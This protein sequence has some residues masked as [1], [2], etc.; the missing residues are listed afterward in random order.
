M[1]ISRQIEKPGAARRGGG[2]LH[3]GEV[4]LRGEGLDGG[5]PGTERLGLMRLQ[6]A[7]G[8]TVGAHL[9]TVS[10]PRAYSGGR[11]SVEVSDG[12]WKRE[13]E[14]LGP[15]ILE[16]LCALLPAPA[17]NEISYRVKPAEAQ[18]QPPGPHRGGD[19]SLARAARKTAGHA[20]GKTTPLQLS[21]EALRGRLDQVIERYLSMPG[22][23]AAGEPLDH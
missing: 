17:V 6:A 20:T 21:D 23:L 3:L 4:A 8:Q 11:L 2:F 10:R 12:T 14:R 1:R 7:W 13:L 16:R 19:A 9:K 5:G 15:A 18:Q 22:R